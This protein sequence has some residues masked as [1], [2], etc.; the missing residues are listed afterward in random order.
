MRCYIL[1]YGSNS[2]GYGMLVGRFAFLVFRT[3]RV[4]PGIQVIGILGDLGDVIRSLLSRVYSQRLIK[5]NMSV[6]RY[7]KSE[8][9]L[10]NL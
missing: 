2:L 4:K 1:G 8:Y 5:I 6:W 3:S 9:N 7:E 10:G